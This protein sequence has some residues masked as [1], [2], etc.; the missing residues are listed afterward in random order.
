MS[1][2]TAPL[3]RV[4]GLRV[5]FAAEEGP[6]KAVRGIDL[7]IDEGESVGLV[8][9]SGCGKTVTAL[10]LMQL[11]PRPK[12]RITEGSIRLRRDGREIDLARLD[13]DGSAIR[14]IRGRDIAMVFQE[15]MTSLNPSFTIGFQILEAIKLHQKI[16]PR[17]MKQTVMESLSLVSIPDP[18]DTMQ[19]YPHELSGG[20]RQRA[21]I[22][23]AIACTPRLLIADEPTT[24]LD[25]T[26]QAQILDL[27]RH[28]Q[29]RRGMSLL[30]IT[31]DL[32]VVGELCD[33]V[34]VMYLGQ[35]VEQN[36][37]RGIF[38]EP[39]HPYTQ[40]LLT[41]I[42][43]IGG[44]R[45]ELAQIPGNVP[46]PTDAPRGCAFAPRC[47]RAFDRCSEPP[48]LFPVDGCQVRCWLYAD[49]GGNSNG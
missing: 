43:A 47:S 25:V 27:M 30:W 21:M 35:V 13:V 28:Y 11:V 14:D 5:E 38:R 17:E 22:A 24:A 2:P 6:V 8:G 39:K 37:A 36:S 31:H 41:C 42:P 29:Q 45:T 12:G 48:D 46:Q 33:R 1:T 20:M 32:G 9:E 10:A 49:H 3:L 4:E 34:I 40:G 26:V 16:P 44:G 19:R 23:M 15:P 7:A 18:A